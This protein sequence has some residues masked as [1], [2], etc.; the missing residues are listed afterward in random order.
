MDSSAL[1]QDVLW[2]RFASAAFNQTRWPHGGA[3]GDGI[4]IELA[5]LESTISIASGAWWQ[6]ATLILT[7]PKHPAV[8]VDALR[9]EHSPRRLRALCLSHIRLDTTQASVVPQTHIARGDRQQPLEELDAVQEV[10][11]VEHHVRLRQVLPRQVREGLHEQ[12]HCR[13]EPGDEF[14]AGD[15]SAG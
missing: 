14:V 1:P 5:L 7:H 6:E 3:D 8:P 9:W 10:V 15:R 11:H 2:S 12:R 13:L 4:G